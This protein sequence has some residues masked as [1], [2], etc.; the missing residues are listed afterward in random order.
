MN[1]KCFSHALFQINSNI[2]CI[3][4][5]YTLLSCPDAHTIN[6]NIGCIETPLRLQAI[7]QKPLINSN[8]GCIETDSK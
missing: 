5:W 4:T 1:C 2:G 8:I 7:H 6:S 3:E